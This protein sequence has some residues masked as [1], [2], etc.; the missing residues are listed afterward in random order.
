MRRGYRDSLTRD[1]A[2]SCNSWF[3]GRLKLSAIVV[4][5]KAIFERFYLVSGLS[6]FKPWVKCTYAPIPPPLIRRLISRF[7]CK[8]FPKWPLVFLINTIHQVIWPV[9]VPLT[10]LEI[11]NEMQI[12]NGGEI[13]V[14]F[15]LN[16]NLVPWD[17]AEIKSNP[18][19]CWR[20]WPKTR[21]THPNGGCMGLC[22]MT[23]D[24]LVWFCGTIE[25]SL[26]Q[27]SLLFWFLLNLF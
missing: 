19:R 7:P 2:G 9:P 8:F 10:R 1:C 27:K 24:L 14:K 25:L 18:W 13:L 16:K 15:E 4:M 17:T 3:Q 26:N 6:P 23:V 12:L 11:L 5:A 20:C 21:K 22:H